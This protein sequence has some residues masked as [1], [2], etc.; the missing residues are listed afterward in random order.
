V[1]WRDPYAKTARRLKETLRKLSGKPKVAT[2]RER[3]AARVTV[4][5]RAMGHEGDDAV[6]APDDIDRI[7]A[8]HWQRAAGAWSW[9]TRGH[10]SLGSQSP[11]K[12][13]ARAVLVM[14][15][16]VDQYS[17]DPIG[18]HDHPPS[19]ASFGFA[20]PHDVSRVDWYDADGNPIAP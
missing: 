3:L 15:Q 12:A 1:K 13:C 6:V 8:G 7:H 5:L 11:M 2:D 20:K 14:S 4:I 9:G 17:L 16:C 18:A 19:G 10:V